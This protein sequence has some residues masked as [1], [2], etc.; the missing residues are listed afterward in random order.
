MARYILIDNYSG[1]IFGDTADMPDH[2]FAGENYPV[3][4]SGLDI[5]TAARWLDEAVIGE[6][7]RTYETKSR[8]DGDECGYLVYRADIDGSEAVSI[9]TDGQDREQIDGV[10]SCCR[11]EGFVAVPRKAD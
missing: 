1:Y 7:Q 8:P 11:Y 3:S 6:F 10:I 5:A 4:Q 2:V 9:V